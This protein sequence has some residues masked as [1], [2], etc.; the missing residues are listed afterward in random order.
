MTVRRPWYGF[1]YYALGAGGSFFAWII[2]LF[3]VYVTGG[4]A[5]LWAANPGPADARVADLVESTPRW[6]RW[7]RVRGVEVDLGAALYAARGAPAGGEGLRAD[8][9]LI[10]PDHPAA[11]AWRD[12]LVEIDEARGRLEAAG[13]P[14]SDA[15]LKAL[16]ALLFRVDDG[17]TG[18]LHRPD[19]ALVVIAREPGPALT[20]PP[21][22]REGPTADPGSLVER[23]RRETRARVELMRAAVR[24][25]SEREG[26]L[27][28]LPESARRDYERRYGAGVAEAALGVGLRPSTVAAGV[29][30]ACI[31]T[32]FFLA[33]GLR[34]GGG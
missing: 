30:A 13:E 32:L 10:G 23:W 12:L 6:R 28:P 21:P 11:L 19:R 27:E 15:H 17:R 3:G 24:A 16:Q 26:L 8:R 14:E 22:A 29:F 31:A 1:L 4:E 7:V 34:A 5:V 33:I 18:K 2:A 9:I 25:E 20:L